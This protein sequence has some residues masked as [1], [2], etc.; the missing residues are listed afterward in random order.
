MLYLKPALQDYAWGSQTVVQD[1]LGIKTPEIIAEMWLG[2]HPKAP[3]MVA[4]Q[5]LDRQIAAE[6][7]RFGK[8]G[9][10]LSYLLKILAAEAPLS[11]QVHPNKT[12]AEMGWARE[13]AAG[14]PVESPFRNYRDDNHKPELIMALSPFE[15]LCGIRDYRQ[16]AEIWQEMGIGDLFKAFAAF[17]QALDYESF[18]AL[19][20]EILYQPQPELAKRLAKLKIKSKYSKEIRCA[21]KL[22][23]FY[24][25]DNFI[26]APFIMNLLYLE[27]FSA[28][29]LDAGIPHAYLHGAGV[30]IMASGDN[31]LRAGLSP[32]HIDKAELL[33]IVELKP[34]L[35]EIIQPE[36]ENN[37]LLSYPVPVKDFSL[38]SCQIDGKMELNGIKNPAIVLV[39]E[40]K[41]E[42]KGAVEN[43]YLSKGEAIM[44]LQEDMPLSAE[45]EGYFVVA[46]P[47]NAGVR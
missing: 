4:G 11:I 38:F 25:E 41:L 42:I 39:L 35:P 34:Y 24:P 18:K 13:E 22:L 6:P 27:P 10:G 47:G 45:G 26:L 37:K 32:K 31:V 19:Y 17:C 23:S 5:P 33:K 20:Q 21:Q 14:I 2:A 43:R 44:L 9:K 36:A 3:S 16:M 8:A 7:Q 15:A 40:G 1:L 12:Q 30:E 46:M 29:Y 28:I